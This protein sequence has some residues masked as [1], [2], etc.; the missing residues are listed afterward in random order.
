MA[1][2]RQTSRGNTGCL[3]RQDTGSVIGGA[4]SG[5]L[6]GERP[7]E[8]KKERGG[9]GG[10]HTSE[11]GRPDH[12]GM[13]GSRT[14][15]VEDATRPAAGAEPG[16]WPVWN[17][18]ECGFQ[19]FQDGRCRERSCCSL[20]SGQ[21][22]SG[23][24]LAMF[25]CY[26]ARHRRPRLKS[27]LQLHNEREVVSEFSILPQKGYKIAQRK[28]LIFWSLQTILQYIEGKLAGQGSW[29]WLL[30]LVTCDR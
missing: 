30:A 3:A 27:K 1:S 25:A 10:T 23:T 7:V 12:P 9:G 18:E 22:G 4:D 6:K 24:S 26:I 5:L 21:T 11:V 19:P 29:L 8:E 28:K 2:L 14:E 13:L 17:N 15:G 20:S 16:D